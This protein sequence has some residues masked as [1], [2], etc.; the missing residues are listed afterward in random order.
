MKT[1]RAAPIAVA[2]VAGLAL[3]A[4]DD[5]SSSETTRKFLEEAEE[6]RAEGRYRAAVV[7]L[8]NAIQSSPEDPVSRRLLGET[9]LALDAYAQ[10]EKELDRAWKLGDSTDQLRLLRV[11][12]KRHLGDSK[13]VIEL[14]R[15]TST[16]NGAVSAA[17]IVQRAAA[18]IESGEVEEGRRLLEEINKR[19]PNA[20]AHLILARLAASQ[21]D[22]ALAARHAEQAEAADPNDVDAL[23]VSGEWLRKNGKLEEARAKLLRARELAPHSLHAAFA[24]AATEIERDET[25]AAL[26]IIDEA[27][28]MDAGHPM[29]RYLRGLIALRAEDYQL[30]RDEAD[31]VISKNPRHFPSM[32]LAGSASARLG[33]LETAKAHL[34]N[35]LSVDPS[36][37]DARLLSAWVDIQL[38]DFEPAFQTL[39]APVFSNNNELT[40]LQ[41]AMTAAIRAGKVEAAKG[42]TERYLKAKPT[43]GRARSAL[44]GLR[45]ASGDQ[46]GAFEELLKGLEQ[47]PNSE[48]NRADVAATYILAGELDKALEQARLLQQEAPDLAVG[49][50]IEGVV[51]RRQDK[52]EEAEQ[53]FKKALE[54][55][56]GNNLAARNLAVVRESAGNLAGAADALR[57]A[58]TE[59][60]G[61]ERMLR[62]L[63]KIEATRGN[64]DAAEEALKQAAEADPESVAPKV[65][66][67][68]LYF[69]SQRFDLAIEAAERVLGIDPENSTAVETRGMALASLNR[70][71]EAAD[72]YLALAKLRPDNP[73]P[74]F[75]AGQALVRAQ[76]LEEAI[77]AYDRALQ[78]DPAF[79]DARAPLVRLLI[80]TEK[81]ERARR[82]LVVLE[83]DFPERADVAE[84]RGWYALT[85]EDNMEQAVASYRRAFEL[86]SVNGRLIRL[87]RV[88]WQAGQQQE[89][90]EA[91]TAWLKENP[92]D[93][94]VLKDLADLQF[95]SEDYESARQT[96][97]KLT[98]LEPKNPAHLNNLAIVLLQ[99]D[100]AE[101]AVPFVKQALALAPEESG[102]L[103]TAGLV[104]LG[105]GD[106]AAALGH[107]D[108]A[109][110]AAPDDPRIRF[111]YAQALFQNRQ[112]EE[113]ESVLSELLD[114]AP[115]FSDA[116]AARSLL[117][118]I[119][120]AR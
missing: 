11:K 89:A 106:T 46:E 105:Q 47:G 52:L 57:S 108:K 93:R 72:A 12:A 90:I 85:V 99:M 27:K 63:A 34:S 13:A 9:Y 62:D 33:E 41:L 82:E 97:E 26:K 92:S 73:R 96:L 30:A 59:N 76:R 1:L 118:K 24:L 78:V 22:V 2:L 120:N 55:A 32:Y 48:I 104:S 17:L 18:F 84:L 103:D 110:A 117:E 111:H 88:L 119:Q 5:M 42:F 35:Y 94:A 21:G 54:I 67:A 95:V 107:L 8:K 77:A 43:D 81:D 102:T 71:S 31:A 53:A 91:F 74:L 20:A 87:A 16:Q 115:R 28:Q 4:C 61:H 7:E 39:T 45:M 49:Y 10:A 19:G 56:P 44:A 83:R 36:S 113:A 86:Q 116:E 3:A 23:I 37:R 51:L 109:L 58:L 6:H 50:T 64:W 14:T 79:H 29:T 100:D 60:P 40:Y 70:D 69:F 112:L 101:G 68:R 98:A 114:R 80:L 15:D 38:E 66:L 65:E 25:E 75:Q